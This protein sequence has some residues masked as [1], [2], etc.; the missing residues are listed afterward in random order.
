MKND[1]LLSGV[2]LKNNL[3]KIYGDLG[4]KLGTSF[5]ISRSLVGTD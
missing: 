5:I 1:V 4:N 3:G 2:L